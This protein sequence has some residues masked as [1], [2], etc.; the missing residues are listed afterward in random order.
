MLTSCKK[1]SSPGSSRYLLWW[2]IVANM[3]LAP[4][5]EQ[6]SIACKGDIYYCFVACHIN[7]PMQAMGVV[8]RCLLLGVCCKGFV[9]NQA[10]SMEGDDVIKG[11]YDCPARNDR[12]LTQGLLSCVTTVRLCGD[13]FPTIWGL[14]NDAIRQRVT[15]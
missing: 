14:D 11:L 10:K 15:T 1:A 2:H 7:C 9:H 8:A 5:T 3:L 6:R 13:R 4:Q 12:A